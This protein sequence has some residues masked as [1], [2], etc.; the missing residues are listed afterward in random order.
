MKLTIAPDTVLRGFLYRF[1]A[2]VTA[3]EQRLFQWHL[4]MALIPERELI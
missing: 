2:Q 4:D 1:R 3:V